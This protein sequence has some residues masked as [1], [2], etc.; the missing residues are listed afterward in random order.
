MTTTAY[1]LCQAPSCQHETQQHATLS[2]D[3]VPKASPQ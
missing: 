3:L 1:L 2:H